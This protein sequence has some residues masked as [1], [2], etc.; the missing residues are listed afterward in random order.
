MVQFLGGNGFSELAK[1]P[2]YNAYFI[3]YNKGIIR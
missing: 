3:V 1:L 2:I